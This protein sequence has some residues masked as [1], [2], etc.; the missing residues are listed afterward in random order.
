MYIA[1]E[2]FPPATMCIWRFRFPLTEYSCG[3][4]IHWYDHLSSIFLLIVF[5]YSDNYIP[6]SRWDR[7]SDKTQRW[8]RRVA[9]PPP[10]LSRRQ[11]CSH[12]CS[13]RSSYSQSMNPDPQAPWRTVH[14]L[15]SPCSP[16][17]LPSTAPQRSR[18]A[19]AVSGKRYTRPSILGLQCLQVW[20]NKIFTSKV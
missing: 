19:A 11:C 6:V 8:S 20:N 13:D 16:S 4:Y 14:D 3:P 7:S 12:S 18:R 1:S 15:C 9:A 2:K 17:A 10:W 5:P